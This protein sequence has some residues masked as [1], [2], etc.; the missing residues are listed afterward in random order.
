MN[1]KIVRISAVLAFITTCALAQKQDSVKV[2]QLNE[3]VISDTKFAQSKEKSGKVITKITQEELLKKSGQNI[4]QILS[5]VAGVEI[6]GNQSAN[7]KNLGYYVRGGR[8]RQVLI[9]I[10]GIPVTDASGISF[11]YD[12]RLLPVDQV[13]SIEIMK[14]AS[15]TLYGS[16]AAT[17]VINI[18]LKKASKKAI[19][20]NAYIN[21][22][23]NNT[24]QNSKV[25]GQDFNQ[26]FSVNGTA[27]KVN[28]LASVNSSE[29]DGMSQIANFD[30]NSDYE[31]D[32]FSRIN[33][34]SKIGFKATDKLSLDFFGNY[35]KINNNYDLVYDNTAFNDTNLNKT[36]S[37]QFRFGF[38][39]KYQYA[40]GE[41]III[42]SFNKIE[43]KYDDFNSFTPS[44]DASLYESRSVN[45]DAFNKYK[46]SNEFFLVTGANYQFHDMLSQTIY[47]NVAKEGTKFNMI[48]P[49][50]TGVFTSDFGLNLNAGARLNVHSEYGNQLVYNVN[51]SFS[52]G[53]N[54]DVK[55]LASYST[56]FITPSLYQLY[57]EYGNLNLKPEENG[58]I[59]A[60]FEVNLLDKK[61]NFNA[62]GFYREQNNTIGFFFD[63]ITFA[64]Q[65]ITIEGINK[66]KGVETELSYAVNSKIKL[67]TNYTFTQVDEAL[68]RLIPK[69]KVNASLDF[70]ASKRL[71]LN[72]NYQYVD[73]RKDAFFDGT[74]FAVANVNLSSYR[75][76]NA[77]IKYELVK[78]RL[79]IFGAATNIF[80]EDF[81]ENIG[82]STRGR[83]FRLGLNINL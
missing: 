41:F 11:E 52:F 58:T 59:E 36:T 24:A 10:D 9:I 77:L 32:R 21:I 35:D 29:S 46:F 47:A 73:A 8:N 17:A 69:H 7:G 34:L 74:T 80:N 18:T 37:E 65:Y 26:G 4:A 27:S 70:Q 62:V 2:N 71:F 63:N 5:T 44:I 56:A 20:G 68:D 30:A 42:S 72:A 54:N 66:A 33:Y 31:T 51:P 3:V 43:R 12:L 78:S 83:N 22:G 82:Y 38:S 14:G 48:D 25:N 75:L 45:V 60:G 15:S 6:N 1:K 16:G 64:G 49:Y 23:S 55:V 81:V 39:P 28:Y 76:V 61:L 19:N 13:E 67:N 79:T 40:K 57:A 53:K 50:V